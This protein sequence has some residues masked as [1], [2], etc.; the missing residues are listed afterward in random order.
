M[1]ADTGNPRARPIT[2]KQ[3][4]A[5]KCAQRYRAVSEEDYRAM[6]RGHFGAGSCTELDRRQA[7]ELLRRLHGDRAAPEPE[8]AARLPAGAGNVTRLATPAQRRYIEGLAAKIEWGTAEGFEGW[9]RGRMGL[10]SVRTSA[11]ASKV[12]DGLRSIDARRNRGPA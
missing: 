12:I 9:L 2:V 6:L 1:P 5:I 7:S 10:K 4:R 11:D 3:I 8:P